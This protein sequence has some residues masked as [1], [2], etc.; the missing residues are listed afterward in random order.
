MNTK[1]MYS[2]TRSGD[3][4]ITDKPRIYLKSNLELMEEYER[5]KRERRIF[6]TRNIQ[7]FRVNSK[8]KILKVIKK[9]QEIII[10][11]AKSEKNNGRSNI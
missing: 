6:I 9:L 2:F 3:D 5:M 1:T 8:K 10:E 4:N 7:P 11:K